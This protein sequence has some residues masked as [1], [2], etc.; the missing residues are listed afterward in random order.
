MPSKITFPSLL[1]LFSPVLSPALLLLHREV[2]AMTSTPPT[3]FHIPGTASVKGKHTDRQNI[4][5]ITGSYT[6]L[7]KRIIPRYLPQGVATPGIFVNVG[8]HL[9][10]LRAILAK[11]PLVLNVS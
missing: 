8:L 1:S 9:P 3:S 4:L 2:P 10:V 6:R 7:G 5:N 11:L